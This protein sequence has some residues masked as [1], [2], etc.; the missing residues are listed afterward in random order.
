MSR[1]IA[2]TPLLPGLLD[3]LVDGAEPE[4]E[5]TSLTR[6]KQAI[7]RDISWL[8]NADSLDQT[9]D[10]KS[11]PHVAASTLNFGAP[12]L[13]GKEREGLD[14]YRLQQDITRS[15]YRFEGRL[16]AE[17]V[18]VSSIDDGG[19]GGAIHLR[20]EADLRAEPLPVRLV[21]RTE[22]DPQTPMIRV[23][24]HRSEDFA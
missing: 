2:R 10:L 11:Y 14:L 21:M 13:D 19:R 1:N 18:R 23:V 5:A 3:R 8:L 20:I 15:L 12:A 7:L 22:I 6:L 4:R 17:T 16:I 9:L 24:E